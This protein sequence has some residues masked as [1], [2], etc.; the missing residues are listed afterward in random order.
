M[1][2]IENLTKRQP[3]FVTRKPEEL[4]PLGASAKFFNQVINPLDKV[5][6]LILYTILKSQMISQRLPVLGFH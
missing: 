1:H 4:Y 6:Y 5:I 2:G 3:A